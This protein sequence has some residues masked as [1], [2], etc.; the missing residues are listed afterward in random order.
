[1]DRAKFD[2]LLLD[3][4]M[5]RHD[6]R[7]SQTVLS[8][9]IGVAIALLGA[10]VA[11]VR[12]G[13]LPDGQRGPTAVPVEVLALSPLLPLGAISYILIIGSGMTVRSFYMRALEDEIRS[14]FSCDLKLLPGVKPF[15]GVE[16]AV[17]YVSGRRGRKAIRVANVVLLIVILIVFG[18][19]VA[20]IGIVLP[21]KYQLAMAI[22]YGPV[23]LL[24]FSE[25]I[26]ALILGRNIFRQ[27]LRRFRDKGYRSIRNVSQEPNND[28]R[29]IWLYLLAPRPADLIKWIFV[30]VAVLVGLLLPGSRPLTWTL[31]S[32]GLLSW[33]ML[34]YLLYYFRYQINDIRGVKSD[35]EHHG[36]RSRKRL[37][38]R[39]Y[40]IRR[41]IA[42]S[43]VVAVA[44][45]GLFASLTAVNILNLSG[46]LLVVGITLLASTLFY[47]FARSD[48]LVRRI[49]QQKCAVLVWTIIG[50]GYAIRV[51]LGLYLAGVTSSQTLVLFGA[52]AWFFG[53]MFV[54]MTWLV[55]AAGDLYFL[56]ARGYVA[57]GD[58]L[59]RKPHLGQ[60]LP[61]VG[62]Y[63]RPAT[64]S[65]LE[66]IREKELKK[67]SDLSAY[68]LGSTIIAPWHIGL[69]A[70]VT[71]GSIAC[72]STVPI[73]NSF[74]SAALLALITTF[75][76]A[77]LCL[78]QSSSRR[79]TS[80]AIVTL[81]IVAIQA[82]TGTSFGW[83]M[84]A[85]WLIFAGTI[86][87]FQDLSY[88]NV[89]E[90]SSRAGDMIAHVAG[91]VWDFFVKLLVGR[92]TWTLISQE[93]ENDR[94]QALS[95]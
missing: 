24:L 92:A 1:M 66:Q 79:A 12:Q 86:I 91:S 88:R 81:G 7:Q 61:F 10:L 77:L 67:C 47:E 21:P 38:T 70:S 36:K 37:P 73:S 11:A 71:L 25:G 65:D 82:V 94:K 72:L 30:P 8:A 48:F 60:L 18:G 80:F 14:V 23:S 49:S 83:G 54:T 57:N 78:R 26:F 27:T 17:S 74:G 87:G 4:E 50:S 69:V 62:I 32:S 56:E 76:A 53:T 51:C 5:A 6:D 43:L 85:M 58:W 44:R 15:S 93:R 31:V 90:F 55:E 20:Y 63:P 68:A 29:S 41:S 34:E 95:V 75:G 2:A 22:A 19:V 9:M 39:R 52:A 64:R 84:L 42:I 33:I 45:L 89:E 28:E 16:F 59:E 40:G 35:R 13:V 3:Y 46:T